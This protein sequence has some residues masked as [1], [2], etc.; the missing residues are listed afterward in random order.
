MPERSPR[1]DYPAEIPCRTLLR[2]PLPVVLSPLAILSPT[3]FQTTDKMWARLF[4]P[5][6]VDF[7]TKN[8]ILRGTVQGRMTGALLLDFYA[9]TAKYLASRPPCRGIFDFSQATE[10]EVSTHAIRQLAAA[11]P[12]FPPGY[13]RILVIPKDYIYGLARMF[14][15]LSEKARPELQVVRT[16]DEAYRLLN[17]ESPDFH[18][19]DL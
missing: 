10:F 1:L 18:P 8:N 9:T 14:Q 12:A 17:V 5:I 6:V 4:V 3:A 16:M 11:P 15:I 2:T 13:M 19:I 7:D